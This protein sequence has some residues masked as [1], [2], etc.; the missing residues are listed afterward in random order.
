MGLAKYEL[1]LS[2]KNFCPSCDDENSEKNMGQELYFN[3]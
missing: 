1:F 3:T 2:S